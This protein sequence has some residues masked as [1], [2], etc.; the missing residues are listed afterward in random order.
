[1]TSTEKGRGG[2]CIGEFVSQGASQEDIGQDMTLPLPVVGVGLGAR[3]QS[4]EERRK[5][6]KLQFLRYHGVGLDI[7]VVWWLLGVTI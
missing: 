1:M 5:A 2:L 6:D 4:H 7:H 3:V